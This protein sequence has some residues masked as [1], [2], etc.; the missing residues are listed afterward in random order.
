MGKRFLFWLIV[1][2]LILGL[3]GFWYYASVNNV[4]V[5]EK[6]KGGVSVFD[7]EDRDSGLE[8]EESVGGSVND[9]SGSG[10]GSEGGLS[11]GEGSDGDESVGVG[12]LPLDLESVPCGFYFAEYD[13]CTGVCPNGICVLEGRSCYCKT[14]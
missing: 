11:S 1:I 7:G 10:S 6:I 9:G 13:I 12:E 4:S 5:F 14:V 8:D 3:V 2:I